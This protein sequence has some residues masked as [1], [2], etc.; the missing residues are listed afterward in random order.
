MQSN[1]HLDLW[2]AVVV[3]GAYH[4]LNPGMGWPLAVSNGLFQRRDRAVFSALVPLAFGH[5]A[6]MAV[7]LLPFALLAFYLDWIRPICI[8]AGLIVV[9]FGLYKLIDR[10]HPRLLA[11]VR[12]TQIALW[13]MLMATAHG[14]G[15]MLVPIYL[16]LCASSSGTVANAAGQGEGAMAQLM[17]SSIATAV[18][19]SVVHTLAMV[20]A[21]GGIAWSVYR[22]FGLQ[23]LRAT[24][25]NLDALWAF[26]LILSGTI[27]CAVAIAERG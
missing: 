17:K 22:H 5:F 25:F 7:A 6:A 8:G 20:L 16:G 1:W 27:G 9:G 2:L 21:G 26:G 13:S 14:A 15:L 18:A 11:R 4:G 12:P 19:V 24:W 23:A 3:V 10:R